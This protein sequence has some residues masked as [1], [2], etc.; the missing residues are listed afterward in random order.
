MKHK[1]ITHFARLRDADLDQ[2]A[3]LIGSKMKGNPYFPTLADQTDA[4]IAASEAY[5]LALLA[6][7]DGGRIAHSKKE[8]TRTDLVEALRILGVSINI[9]A[10]G[11][12]T[13]LDSTGFPLARI[14]VPRRIVKDGISLAAGNRSV[15]VTLN[16]REAGVNYVV[17]YTAFPATADSVWT[18]TYMTDKVFVV[19]GLAP[20]RKY[21]FRI[22]P[23][24]QGRELVF[25]EVIVSKYVE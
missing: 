8:G 9:L 11:D 2:Q 16:N 17:Q 15:T 25:G 13:M 14:A 10:K 3:Q 12:R 22:A 21:A 7:L 20:D 23:I 1:I 5:H 19:D 6:A 4:V 18:T 24:V